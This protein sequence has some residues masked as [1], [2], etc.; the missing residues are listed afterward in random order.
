MG[1]LV[2]QFK[3]SEDNSVVSMETLLFSQANSLIRP[4]KLQKLFAEIGC[5]QVIQQQGCD[6]SY[7]VLFKIIPSIKFNVCECAVVES[8]STQYKSTGMQYFNYKCD[9]MATI[10]TGT[11][12][13][14]SDKQL[15]VESGGQQPELPFNLDWPTLCPLL[16]TLICS[17][18]W[19][20][21]ILPIMKTGQN[22]ISL[23]TC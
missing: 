21:K 7:K 3:E 20:N 4:Q 2:R 8:G 17:K 1:K 6:N 14:L 18:R 9:F 15:A 16:G 13:L 12:S 23:F 11:A 22:Q 19:S 10:Q 5:D